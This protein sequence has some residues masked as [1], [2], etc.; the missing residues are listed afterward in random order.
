MRAITA[1]VALYAFVLQAFLGGLMPIQG[2]GP[3]GVLCLH[4]AE[5]GLADP[6]PGT[7]LP[8]HHGDC[9]TAAPLAGSAEPPR[10]VGVGLAWSLRNVTRVSWHASDAVAARAPPNTIA[11]PRGPPVT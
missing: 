8:A 4:A 11:H 1:V 10:P 3:D 7:P 6:G 2:G 5:T 9:C